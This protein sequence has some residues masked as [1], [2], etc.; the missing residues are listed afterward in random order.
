MHHHKRET[1]EHFLLPELS[2]RLV[3]KKERQAVMFSSAA[4]EIKTHHVSFVEFLSSQKPLPEASRMQ[5]AANTAAEC[6]YKKSLQ[7]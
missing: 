1:N 2:A 5:N 3:P 7:T 6:V 4:S